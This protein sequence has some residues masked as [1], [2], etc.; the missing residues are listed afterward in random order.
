MIF[1]LINVYRILINYF[2]NIKIKGFFLQYAIKMNFSKNFY[3]YSF[4]TF[5]RMKWNLIYYYK[6]LTFSKLIYSKDMF[7]YYLQYK[8]ILYK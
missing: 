4:I 6:C 7:L 8:H 1:I 2:L 5:G 3:G